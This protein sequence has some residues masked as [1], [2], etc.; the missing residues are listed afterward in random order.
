MGG[1]APEHA[2]RRLT[3]SLNGTFKIETHSTPRL[4]LTVKMRS[5][6]QKG[7]S[8]Q[9][10][11]GRLNSQKDMA[12]QELRKSRVATTE[13]ASKVCPWRRAQ[14]QSTNKA[15]PQEELAEMNS[16]SRRGREDEKA[17][18]LDQLR[19]RP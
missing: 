17:N 5:L 15:A 10:L 8:G 4:K 7:S 13:L 11:E 6:S 16:Q 2:C 3:S 9:I 1:S 18:W 19:Q 14:T 12:F